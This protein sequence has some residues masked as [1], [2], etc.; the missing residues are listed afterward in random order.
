VSG[1]CGCV[2]RWAASYAAGLFKFVTHHPRF[3]NHR[4]LNYRRHY[5]CG[6]LE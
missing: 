4:A 2:L 1:V 3:K 6:M 5:C